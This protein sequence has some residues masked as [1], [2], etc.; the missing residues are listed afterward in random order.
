[1]EKLSFESDYTQGA[2]EEI[3]RALARFYGVST[4][5]LLE[6]TDDPTPPPPS[7]NA[8]GK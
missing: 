2:H 4:D 5:Y 1:M 7:R 3:L 8:A 6:L